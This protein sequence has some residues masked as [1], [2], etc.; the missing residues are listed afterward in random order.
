MSVQYLC[1][2]V[3]NLC[4]H[5]CTPPG[6][7]DPNLWALCAENHRLSSWD[8]GRGQ[9]HSIPWPCP[10][11]DGRGRMSLRDKTEH[12]T[13]ERE[14]GAGVSERLNVQCFTCLWWWW[15]WWFLLW[16]LNKT[17]SC[18]SAEVFFSLGWGV[19]KRVVMLIA[20]SGCLVATAAHL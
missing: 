4:G 2:Y 18:M 10:D 6:P 17:R 3:T 15:W 7:W 13:R 8:L 14:C 5:C 1:V 9:K 12:W 19:Q 16:F 20:L 11:W